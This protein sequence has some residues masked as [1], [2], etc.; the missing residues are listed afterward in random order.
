MKIIAHRGASDYH[1]ENTLAAFH[2]AIQMGVDGIELDVRLTKDGVPVISHDAT[3]NRLSNGKGYIHQ[4]T[5]HELKQFRF[6]HA[7]LPK[8]EPAEI[9][10]LEEVFQLIGDEELELH[11][12]LKNGPVFAK[13]LEEKV[14]Q[15]S[16][17]YQMEER[18]IYSSFDHDCLKRIA[19]LNSQAK[20]APLFYA[21]LLH[22]FDYID[23]IGLDIHSIHPTHYYVTDEM[24]A[25]AHA[26][27]ILVHL[28]TVNN[29]KTAKKY[30]DMGVDGIMT[31][32]PLI[33]R[34]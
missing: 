13:Y 2:T 27:G 32:D 6:Q 16:A 10:T 21:N 28:Y 33:L 30:A 1:T 12:E 26:R 17:A 14:L 5:L 22:F 3:I 11:I 24:I 20:I 19:T 15:L 34:G 25:Q 23:Q 18:V 31:D 8:S 29:A 9:A 4:M 7:S